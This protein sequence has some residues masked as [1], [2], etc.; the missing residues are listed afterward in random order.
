MSTIQ[1][2]E[3]LLM[4]IQTAFRMFMLQGPMAIPEEEMA[5]VR[6]TLQLS[7]AVGP[8]LYPSE[9][10]AGA[11]NIERQNKLVDLYDRT[12]R[13][14]KELFPADKELMP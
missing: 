8:V 11:T 12:V 10:K 13:D 3:G 14:L 5:K 9:Y 4:Q 6:R 1:T 2:Y 7:D